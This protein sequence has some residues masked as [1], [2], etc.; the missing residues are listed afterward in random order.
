MLFGT[1]VAPSDIGWNGSS[2]SLLLDEHA[3]FSVI[4]LA[5]R[6]GVTLVD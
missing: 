5:I 4:D 1:R 6:T 3:H 2:E